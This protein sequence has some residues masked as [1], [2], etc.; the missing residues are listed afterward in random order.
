[1]LEF[2]SK[3]PAA[4]LDYR[5][6]PPIYAGEKLVSATLVKQSG[7]VALGVAQFDDTGL[8]VV[9]SGGTEGLNQ[10]L[11]TWQADSGRGDIEHIQLEVS[12]T[13]DAS[14]PT[15][16]VLPPAARIVTASY[17]ATPVWPNKDPD[18]KLDFGLNVAD[19]IGDPADA[20]KNVNYAL[21]TSDIAVTKYGFVGQTL[22]VWLAGGVDGV[23]YKVTL[24]VRTEKGRSV[25]QTVSIKVVTR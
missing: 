5:W 25:D 4:S 23:T 12:N 19:L 11:G 3:T 17:A 20:I 16:V 6:N 10:F 1:M 24:R 18:D 15:E 9:I 22:V 7:D 2:P 21:A 14:V 8:T 13:A